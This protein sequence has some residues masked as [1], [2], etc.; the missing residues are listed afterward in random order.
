MGMGKGMGMGAS[1][2][3]VAR[4]DT[5]TPLLDETIGANLE[6]TGRVHGD[7]TAFVACHQG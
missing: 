3:S 7:R 2:T 5:D 1:R 4:G 6:R